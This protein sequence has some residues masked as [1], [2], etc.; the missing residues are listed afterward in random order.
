VEW[1]VG[2]QVVRWIERLVLFIR[3]AGFVDV[4]SPSLPGMV[5]ETRLFLCTLFIYALQN[6]GL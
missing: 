2:G 6:V 5:F 1:G 4:L 3:L